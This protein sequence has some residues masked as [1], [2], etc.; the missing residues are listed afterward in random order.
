MQCI[1]SDAD[2]R[3]PSSEER[4]SNYKCKN[5]CE[6]NNSFNFSTITIPN[7]LIF[8]KIW[9]ILMTVLSF[10]SI[11]SIFTKI[12]RSSQGRHWKPEIIGKVTLKFN[13]NRPFKT[14]DVNVCQVN[15]NDQIVS[16]VPG[17]SWKTT[18]NNTGF[19]KVGKG[20]TNQNENQ[21]QNEKSCGEPKVLGKKMGQRI[22]RTMWKVWNGGWKK[23]Q[24]I[25]IGHLEGEGVKERL[26]MSD[27]LP[28][29]FCI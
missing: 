15:K 5:D 25:T 8:F 29:A 1:K 6:I 27:W 28:R 14:I 2:T 13:S 18:S 11:P 20:I 7:F 9:F 16:A 21:N 26:G 4:R 17:K 12:D 10:R 22:E 3:N 24:F 19:N 23:K